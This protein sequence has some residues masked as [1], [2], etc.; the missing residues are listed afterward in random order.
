MFTVD[1]ILLFDAFVRA[2]FLRCFEPPCNFTLPSF[3]AIVS[4]S[5]ALNETLLTAKKVTSGR[6]M[7]DT[8]TWPCHF[9]EVPPLVQLFDFLIFSSLA[10]TFPLQYQPW[11]LQGRGQSRTHSSQSCSRSEKKSWAISLLFRGLLH[12]IQAP[13]ILTNVSRVSISNTTIDPFFAS[14][15]CDVSIFLGFRAIHPRHRAFPH[16]LYCRFCHFFFSNLC[17]VQSRLISISHLHPCP[18]PY[19]PAMRSH[20]LQSFVAPF[21]SQSCFVF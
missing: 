13:T 20:S 5:Q 6:A 16:P 10:S 1:D 12:S 18:F 11:Y 7:N 9:S 21:S 3:T 4:Q 2:R 14:R 19:L 17:C 15:G 8:G